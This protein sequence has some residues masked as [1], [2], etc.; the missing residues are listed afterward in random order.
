MVR[1]ITGTIVRCA[2]GKET[3]DSIKLRLEKPE[4]NAARFV[5]PAPG[6]YLVRVSY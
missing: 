3:L 5:A 6:L 1:L 4:P 2:L